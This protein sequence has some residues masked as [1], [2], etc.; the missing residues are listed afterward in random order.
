MPAHEVTIPSTFP[1]QGTLNIPHHSSDLLPAI[2]FLH[3][4]GPIDRNSDAPG[5]PINLFKQLAEHAA[6]IGFASLRYDK[7]GI[8]ASGGDY[9]AAGM[10]DLVD[11]AVAAVRFLKNQPGIDPE[12]IYVL[13]HSEGAI[14]A[15]QLFEREAV[16]GL[17]LLSGI[18]ESL[19]VTVA[20]QNDMAFT[21]LAKMSGWKGFLIRLF[22][23]ADKGRKDS[24]KTVAKLTN[25][26]TDTIRIKGVK[27]NAKWFREHYAY[28]ICNTLPHV[29]CPTLVVTG[30]KDI[31]VLPEH[32]ET[33]ASLVSGPSEWH[34]IP[35]LHHLLRKDAGEPS[36]LGLKATYKKAVQLPIDK[37][38]LDLINDWLQRQER[39][40]S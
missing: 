21:E 38:L 32:A 2:L 25:S 17:L 10:Y 4:S 6:R 19:K 8:G 14:L 13:G 35:D 12:R 1:L 11:D 28:D 31:Q 20:R 18:A 15:P 36:M 37:E 16:K 23:V 27:V 40:E 22:K 24:D 5:L 30:S 33:I 29:S 9:H 3:G 26:T 39:A 7:R 34:L